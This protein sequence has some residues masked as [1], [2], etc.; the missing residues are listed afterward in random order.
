LEDTTHSIEEWGKVKDFTKNKSPITAEIIAQIAY[1]RPHIITMRPTRPVSNIRLLLNLRSQTLQSLI[2]LGA[3]INIITEI[4]SKRNINKKDDS[5]F[6]PLH[7]AIRKKRWEIVS[8]FY[9]QGAD[10]NAKVSIPP[11]TLYT[12][13]FDSIRYYAPD[14]IIRKL[15]SSENINMQSDSGS[16]ALHMATFLACWAITPDLLEDRADVNLVKE[17]N[18]TAL[19]IACKF[20][21]CHPIPMSIF[22]QLISP[23]N[24]NLANKD[25]DTPLHIAALHTGG[26]FIPTLL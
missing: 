10:I 25:G 7:F 26:T 15:I 18:E 9:H 23:H 2:D 8:T 1:L 24:I 11:K 3:P 4:I 17:R 6:T 13:L 12:I 20:D 16:T 5:G 14:Q 21:F 22:T 19:Y